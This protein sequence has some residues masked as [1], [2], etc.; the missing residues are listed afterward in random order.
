L[1]A[2]G[3]YQI[4]FLG[5]PLLF[6]VILKKILFGLYGGVLIVLNRSK[7]WFSWGWPFIAWGFINSISWLLHDVGSLEVVYRMIQLLWIFGFVSFFAHI[8][9]WDVLERFPIKYFSFACLLLVVSAWHPE[10]HKQIVNGFGGNRFGFSIWLSQFV[11]IVFLVML[12]RQDCR[13]VYGLMQVTPII[14]LQVISAGRTGLLASFLLV[15]YFCHQSQ[16]RNY[17]LAIFY[18]VGVTV[19]GAWYGGLVGSDN[20]QSIYRL[21]PQ[22]G[23][24][25]IFIKYDFLS[26]L[27]R[28]LSYRLSIIITAFSDFDLWNVIIGKGVGNFQGT[29]LSEAA[30][31][32]NIYL[33]SLGEL[34]VIGFLVLLW[35]FYLPFTFRS[36]SPAVRASKVFMAVFLLIGASHSEILITSISTCMVFWIC[37]AKVMHHRSQFLGQLG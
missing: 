37:Y 26:F 35:I 23:N 14:L 25:Y 20:V 27:D 30:Q 3:I 15:L 8:R 17:L 12:D 32:H 4:P 36:D 1:I 13:F 29:M 11:F 34:G 6:S 16:R 7:I 9:V 2:S 10:I 24:D 33:R 5:L 21:T 19:F 18:L 22:L 31:V 28:F